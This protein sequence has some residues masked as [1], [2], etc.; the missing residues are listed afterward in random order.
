MVAEQSHTE[1]W[2][3]LREVPDPEIP[4]INLVELGVVRDIDRNENGRITVT[5]TPTYTACPAKKFFEDLIIEKLRANGFEDIEIITRLDP[6][7]TTDWLS[8]ETKEKLM[9]DGISPPTLNNS[10]VVCP[11]CKSENTQPISEYGSVP[12]QSLYKC[13]DCLEPFSYFKCHR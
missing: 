11:N 6:I 9:K 10:V 1:L 3:L 4:I 5:I 13:I 7:W 8:E 2:D 12:C